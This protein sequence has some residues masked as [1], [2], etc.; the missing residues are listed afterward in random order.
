MVINIKIQHKV[1]KIVWMQ[2]YVD[3]LQ[4]HVRSCPYEPCLPFYDVQGAKIISQIAT[5]NNIR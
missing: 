2:L 5:K 3:K 1:H 4:Y